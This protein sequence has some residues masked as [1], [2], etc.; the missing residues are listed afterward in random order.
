MWVR[1]LPSNFALE[2]LRRYCVC[3][4]EG[5]SDRAVLFGG[6]TVL[7]GAVAFGALQ[8]PKS[9]AGISVSNRVADTVAYPAEIKDELH[10]RVKTFFNEDGFQKLQNSFIVVCKR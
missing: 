8:K 9:A 6:I 1:P 4:M 3:E 10:S 5:L 2:L 7:A